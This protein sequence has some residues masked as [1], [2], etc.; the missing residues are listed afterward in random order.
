MS[1]ESSCAPGGFANPAPRFSDSLAEA[2]GGVR[3]AAGPLLEAYRPYL[4]AIANSE[5]PDGLN[6]KM[7]ASDVV[8]D[9]LVKGLRN[10]GDFLGG[11]PDE[12]GGWLRQILLNE[13]ANHVDAF[14]TAKRNWRLEQSMDS[15]LVDSGQSVPVE[16]VLLQER[17][18]R[19]ESAIAGLPENARTLIELRHHRNMSF[20]EI[21]TTLGKTEAAVRK[22]W[23]RAVHLLQQE[24]ARHDSTSV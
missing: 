17:K 21:A 2:R 12:L 4:L 16:Q 13:I 20:E 7:G 8:Q 10:F 22:A 6:G 9:T 19:L 3:H 18:Q 1:G 11:T 14:H 5:L 23:A 15:G 24:L